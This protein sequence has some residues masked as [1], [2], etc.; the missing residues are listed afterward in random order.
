MPTK[1]EYRD[2]LDA[3]ELSLQDLGLAE[4]VLGWG[5]PRHRPELGVTLKTTTGAVYQIADALAVAGRLMNDF[6]REDRKC[7]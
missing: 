2:A 5:E 7:G 4:L 6:G 3:L 1:Q